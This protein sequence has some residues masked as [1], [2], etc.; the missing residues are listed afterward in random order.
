MR[1]WRWSILA[2]RQALVLVAGRAQWGCEQGQSQRRRP[3]LYPHYPALPGPSPPFRVEA[4][5]AA[6]SC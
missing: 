1:S 4:A 3:C 2:P 6:R 5:E